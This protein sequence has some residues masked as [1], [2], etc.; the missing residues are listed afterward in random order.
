MNKD[1]LSPQAIHFDHFRIYGCFFLFLVYN[2]WWTSKLDPNSKNCCCK[3]CQRHEKAF[4]L[5]TLK[6]F[7]LPFKRL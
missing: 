4:V 6:S 5:F 7:C 2:Q 1:N 3:L